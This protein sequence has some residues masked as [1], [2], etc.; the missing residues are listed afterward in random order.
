MRT[1]KYI[2]LLF[3]TAVLLTGCFENDYQHTMSDGDAF[4][5]FP[6]ITASVNEPDGSIQIPVL[7]TSVS[8][9]AGTVTVEVDKEA[10]TGIAGV[11][12]VDPGTVTLTFPGGD[13]SKATQYVN[14]QVIDNDVF[15]GNTTV[16]LKITSHAGNFVLGNESTCTVNIVDDEHPLKEYL[17]MV[18]LTREGAAG[19]TVMTEPVTETMIV[20]KNFPVSTGNSLYHDVRVKIDLAEGT[21]AIVGEADI[22]TRFGPMQM[23]YYAGTDTSQDVAGVIQEDGTLF[24]PGNYTA[25]FTSGTNEGARIMVFFNTR[26]SKAK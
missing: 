18:E 3:S 9:L 7:L 6:S 14:L 20:I 11:N 23:G 16:V 15:T 25:I 5:A 8:Q 17:G 10:S 13:V 21:C 26:I 4:V 19:Y 2:A 1:I 12:Y 22:D 24:F